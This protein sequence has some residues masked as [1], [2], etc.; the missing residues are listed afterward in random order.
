MSFSKNA[1]TSDRELPLF[2]ES[3]RAAVVRRQIN[4]SEREGET[5]P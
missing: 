1:G 4:L 3:F 2:R 5:D